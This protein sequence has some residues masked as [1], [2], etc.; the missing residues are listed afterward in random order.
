MPSTPRFH[1]FAAFLVVGALSALNC[2]INDSGLVGA[3]GGQQI[4][5]DAGN[6]SSTWA[7]G[8]IPAARSGGAPG[9]GGVPISGTGGATGGA[10]PGTGGASPTGGAAGDPAIG[11]GGQ[12]IGS[13]GVVAGTGGVMGTGGAGTGG[14]GTGGSGTGGSGTGGAAT[15]GA[16]TGGTGRGGAGTG[17]VGTGGAA[18]SCNVSSCPTGCC[19]TEGRCITTESNSRCGTRG[20]ACAV[21]GDCFTCSAGACAL[22]PTS[23]WDIICVSATIAPTRPNGLT[24]DNNGMGSRIPSV[25]RR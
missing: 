4:G 7:G 18:G 10:L 1:F 23:R 11:S 21:C 17:G 22:V 16:E 25:G 19:T 14:V 12:P 20:A 6:D 2:S 9:T 5:H 13:G 24:W 3:G 8:G 15:G